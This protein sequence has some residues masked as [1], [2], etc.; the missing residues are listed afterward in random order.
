M[1]W[2][3]LRAV[4]CAGHGVASGSSASSPY[5]AG[6]IVLQQPFFKQ[7]GLDLSA[8]YPGT[9]NVSI[10]PYTWRLLRADYHFAHVAWTDRHPPEDF[11]FVACRLSYAKQEHHGWVYYPHPETKA[12]H[13]QSPHIIEL[14]LPP[15]ADI[16]YGSTVQLYLP[17][18][19]I[20]LSAL[21]A[22]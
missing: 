21:S 3:A 6:T 17:A 11:S 9:L 8:L 5:P 2:H 12:A 15:I 13:F 19:Q 16:H 14:L 1:M 10:A 18:A 7:R 4:V 20:A 22:E